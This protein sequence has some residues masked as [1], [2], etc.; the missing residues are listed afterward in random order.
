MVLSVS[1]PHIAN[2]WGKV[3]LKKK[4][5]IFLKKKKN[6]QITFVVYKCKKHINLSI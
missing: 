6:I 2:R 1:L 5:H 4:K 3:Y